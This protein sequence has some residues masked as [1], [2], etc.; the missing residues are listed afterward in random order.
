[1]P[2]RS[3][4]L[5]LVV[6]GGLALGA[7]CT[8]PFSTVKVD[9]PRTQQLFDDPAP[10]V[11]GAGRVGT[12]FS[13]ASIEV[14]LD[15]VDLV[16][17]LGLTPPFQ[18]QGGAVSLP[19]GPVTVSG[20]SVFSPGGQHSVAFAVAGLTQ[21]AHTHEIS[22][23]RTAD[24]AVVTSSVSFSLVSPLGLVA[25]VVPAA[26]RALPAIAPGGVLAHQTA[27]EPSVAGSLP[28]PG[29]G[30]LR[31]GFTPVAEALVSAP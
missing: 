21:S 4:H 28:I 7:P 22:A 13:L 30:E 12:N 31:S 23:V 9:K 11:Q 17:A 10:L 19:S 6:L 29:G 16:A 26:A 24:L 3:A 18:N 5:A 14:L 2:S 8:A 27:G 25:Q 20:F 1:M 15:G